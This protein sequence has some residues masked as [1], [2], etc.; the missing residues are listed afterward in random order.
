MEAYLDF[1]I[2]SIY[3]VDDFKTLPEARNMLRDRII[4][5]TLSKSDGIVCDMEEEMEKVLTYAQKHLHAG[6]Q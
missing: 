6:R 1:I 4:S 5:E 2:Q 3:T